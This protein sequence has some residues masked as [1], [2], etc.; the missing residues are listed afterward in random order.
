MTPGRDAATATGAAQE[1]EARYYMRT[2]RRQPVVVVRGEGCWVWDDEGRRYLDLVAGIAVNVLGHC[3]PA[4]TEAITRQ[5][6][7]LLHTSNLYYS[8]PQ[9]EL[10]ELL[11]EHSCADS[12]FFTNSG[13]ESNEGA[14]KLARKYGKLHRDGAF[15]I[16]TAQNSFHGRTLAT[17]AATGQPKYQA[18]FAPMP[19]GF[20]HVPYNDLAALQAATT[21]ETVAVMLEPIQGESGIH[22]ANDD[23]L[24]GVR[25]WCD[26]EGLLL[27]LDEVQTGMART[28]TFFAYEGYGVLPDII[29]LAKGLCGGVPGGAVLA[30]G[31]AACFEPGDHGSTLGGNPL[32]CA[33]GVATVRTILGDELGRHAATIGAYLAAGLQPLQQSGLI[34]AV[35]QRGLMLGIDL[36]SETAAAVVGAAREQGVL[37]NNTGPATLRMVPPLTLAREEVDHALAVL[38]RVLV[39]QPLG[40]SPRP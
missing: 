5:A 26:E 20:R 8:L 37:I 4:V 31:Q 36:A 29:T 39:D 1:R 28:G 12:V 38:S 34:T 24:R 32:A 3:H 15:E 30:R 13:A 2:F 25:R 22:P 7:T 19:A 10:A 17:V 27:I 11:V 9:L 40:E 6:G 14:I 16:L 21:H 23:Y 33:A 18:P 35:R